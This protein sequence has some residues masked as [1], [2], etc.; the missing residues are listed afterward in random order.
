MTA[1]SFHLMEFPVRPFSR[2]LPVV[3]LL[4]CLSLVACGGKPVAPAP[5]PAPSPAVASAPT[6]ASSGV[7]PAP[8]PPAASA[9]GVTVATRKVRIDQ[10]LITRDVILSTQYTNM[11]D[12]VRAL[13]GTW[14]RTR[15]AESIQGQSASLQVY[16]DNQRL[17]GG[18][19]ELR[20]MSPTN[21]E[22]VRFYDPIQASAR[23]GMD[24]GAGALFILTAKK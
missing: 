10:Q 3:P 17:A 1:S 13:R 21:I 16:L 14:M 9:P 12:V 15:P 5:S 6:S 2:A 8:I 22:S 18:V 11:Y 23:W 4:T 20:S 24:H 7:T 19:E